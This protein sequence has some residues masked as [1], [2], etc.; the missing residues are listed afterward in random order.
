MQKCRIK[1]VAVPKRVFGI[2][3]SFVLAITG[4]ADRQIFDETGLVTV[5]GYD[6][7]KS[8]DIRATIVLPSINPEAKQKIQ[9]ISATGETS[10]GMRDKANLQSDKKLLGGQIRVALYNEHFAKKGIGSIVDTLYRDSSLSSRVYLC[11]VEGDTYDMLTYPYT[12]Q[13]NIG[14]YLYR[15]IDQNVRGEKIPSTTMHEFFRSYYGFGVD[16]IMPLIER[17]GNELKIKG[18]A[19]FQGDRYIGWI[20]PKEAFLIKLVHGKF[21]IGSYDTSVPANIFGEKGKAG[22][23]QKNQVKLVFDTIASESD[24]TL[25]AASPPVFDVRVRLQ[26]RILELTIPIKLED[27]KM[28]KTMED[29]LEKEIEKELQKVVKKLQELDVDPAGFGIVYR[30]QQRGLKEMTNRDW[31]K[32]FR[33]ASFRFHVQATIIRNGVMD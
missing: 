26:A 13:G 25:L 17:K 20:T 21:K 2:W 24:M 16:P 14:I 28:M 3:C 27:S 8:G 22:N 9:L 6:L 11:V 23:T 12:E 31:R 33:Q 7:Q 15:M 5:V 1:Q 10:K 29:A 30:A 32:I 4:C 18:V 19:L